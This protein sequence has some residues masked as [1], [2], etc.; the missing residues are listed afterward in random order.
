[1]AAASGRSDATLR[2]N[3]APNGVYR[4]SMKQEDGLKTVP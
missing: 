3:V 4:S 1:M 2:P